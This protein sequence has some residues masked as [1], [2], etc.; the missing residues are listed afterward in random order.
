MLYF[1]KCVLG[2]FAVMVTMSTFSVVWRLRF[3]R[4]FR[5]RVVV[6]AKI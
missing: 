6:I 3:L 2:G 4:Y 5:A 1:A